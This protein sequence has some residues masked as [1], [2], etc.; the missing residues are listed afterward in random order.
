MKALVKP[1]VSRIARVL[2]SIE[3][4]LPSNHPK[5]YA[6]SDRQYEMWKKRSC[7]REKLKRFGAEVAK[8]FDL[9]TPKV[10]RAG[11]SHRLSCFIYVYESP[12]TKAQKALFDEVR[13]YV[14]KHAPKAG[15]DH[16]LR[17]YL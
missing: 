3:V 17:R 9:P 2:Y 11:I 15:P 10:R 5:S 4:V 12:G 7:N 1:H 16:Q 8:K 6:I 14:E 13:A